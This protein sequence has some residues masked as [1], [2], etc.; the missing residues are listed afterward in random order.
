M[1]SL[2][3]INTGTPVSYEIPDVRR[4]L[5]EFLM[6]PY[7]IDLPF[8]KRWLLVH[9]IIL[10]SRPHR[11]SRLY[12]I[13]WTKDGAPLREISKRQASLLSEI[14]GCP[15]EYAF[16][17]STPS[18]EISLTSLLQ[19]GCR[20]ITVLPLFPHYSLATTETIYKKL[21]D[22]SQTLRKKYSYELEI[23]RPFWN[24]SAW[25]QSWGKHVKL[26]LPFETEHLLLTYHGLPERHIFKADVSGCHCLKSEDCCE[27]AAGEKLDYCYRAQTI[28]STQYLVDY[29]G[30]KTGQYSITY[31]S[32]F[33]KGRWLQPYAVE[34]VKTLAMKGIRNLTIVN[35][36]F[37]SDC[38]ETYYEIEHELKEVFIQNGGKF[39]NYIPCMNENV[40]WVKAV[41]EDKV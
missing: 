29:L 17:Y 27:N 10:R 9:G 20:K 40:G 11:L 4:Y 38:L 1:Q 26:M 32:R 39:F 7:I 14:L 15:V 5:A 12:R 22:V 28:Q 13:I 2:I 18:I 3:I 8:W 23:V 31:Q 16:R 34:S 30:L 36:S 21:E 19:R 33:G 41:C 6:D 35:G 24:H 37:V 25:I